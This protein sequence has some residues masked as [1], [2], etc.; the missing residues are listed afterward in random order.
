MQKD[1][2][3]PVCCVSHHPKPPKVYSD[4]RAKV[5][6]T[7]AYEKN[8]HSAGLKFRQPREHGNE[9]SASPVQKFQV[10]LAS[11]GASIRLE[12]SE[13]HKR[14]DVPVDSN[15][16]PLALRRDQL[17]LEDLFGSIQKLITI[18]RFRGHS[19]GFGQAQLAEI[20]QQQ[21]KLAFHHVI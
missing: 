1:G 11:R 13:P 17:C 4:E 12:H 3:P 18:W 14:R 15:S 6:M 20:R 5:D 9:I 2:L 19:V 8:L 16:G 7:A 10:L 21:S